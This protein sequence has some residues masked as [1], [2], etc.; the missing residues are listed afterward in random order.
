MAGTIILY[1]S[2]APP[3]PTILNLGEFQRRGFLSRRVGWC[4]AESLT[5]C[6]I[7]TMR[8]RRSVAAFMRNAFLV[9]CSLG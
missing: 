6:S 4:V 5:G 3:P 2:G 8:G 9:C 1:G 7:P